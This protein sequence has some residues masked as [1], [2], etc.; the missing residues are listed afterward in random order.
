[1]KLPGRRRDPKVF[2]V[3]VQKSGTTAIATLLAR[4]TRQT[5]GSDFTHLDPA[6]ERTRFFERELP[7]DAYVAEHRRDFGR[8]IVKDPNLTFFIG[9]LREA[10]PDAR[11]V[12]ISRDPREQIRSLLDWM[13]LPGD[14]DE[15]DT[16]PLPENVRM[17]LEGRWPAVEGRNYVERLAARWRLGADAYLARRDEVELIRYEDFVADKAGSLD[18]LARR[19][20][21]EPVAD[22]SGEVDEQ[23]Q[24]RGTPRPWAEV[25]GQRNLA[26]VEQA[27]AEQMR[28]L[29]YP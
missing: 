24:S 6:P 8:D 13:G 10:F 19:V 4:L 5:L 25:F 12:F 11:I 2:V 17:L 18:E 14:R 3:G 16:G 7:F 15:V 29:G 9:E 26:L 22:I 27:C 28:E 21:L 20:G 1:V 23:F